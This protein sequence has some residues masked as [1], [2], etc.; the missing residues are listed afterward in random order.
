MTPPTSA[1][2]EWIF[3]RFSALL[4]S[5]KRYENGAKL[6][7]HRLAEGSRTKIDSREKKKRDEGTRPALNSA[8]LVHFDAFI[9]LKRRKRK[10]RNKQVKSGRHNHSQ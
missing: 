7:P 3:S 6:T 9:E 4:F 1:D 2:I 5:L 8:K 10:A